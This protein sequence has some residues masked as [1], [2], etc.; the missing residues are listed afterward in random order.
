MQPTENINLDIP[1]LCSMQPLLMAM[2][3]GLHPWDNAMASM[4]A[5][6]MLRWS[7]ELLL[8]TAVITKH[9]VCPQSVQKGV[10]DAAG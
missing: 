9:A 2:E 8:L 6:R 1:Y 3:C 4:E 7:C 10:I 5:W